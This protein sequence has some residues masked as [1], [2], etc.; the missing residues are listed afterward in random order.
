MNGFVNDADALQLS[1]LP[2]MEKKLSKITPL[3]ET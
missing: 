1:N 2:Q 3:P